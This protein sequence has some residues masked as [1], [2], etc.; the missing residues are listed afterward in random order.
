MKLHF[1]YLIF[2]IFIFLFTNMFSS[3]QIQNQ[4][5]R[6]LKIRVVSHQKTIKTGMGEGFSKANKMALLVMHTL[7]GL[8]LCYCVIHVKCNSDKEQF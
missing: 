6:T 4:P 2:A 3:L 5:I 7:N 8:K 1:R